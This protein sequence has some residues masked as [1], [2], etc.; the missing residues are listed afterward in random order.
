M[1]KLENKETFKNT[2]KTR[3]YGKTRKNRFFYIYVIGPS[4]GK[5]TGC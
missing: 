5:M 3:F 2:F 4:N 1:C